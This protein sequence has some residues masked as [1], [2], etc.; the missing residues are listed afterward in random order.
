[1]EQGAVQEV[2]VVPTAWT[3][4]YLNVPNFRKLYFGKCRRGQP[5]CYH[6]GQ[7]EYEW[8]ECP[9]RVQSRG[10]FENEEIAMNL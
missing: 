9:S 3:R 1:M 5:N 4:P 7:I 10:I 2:W 8:L 6:D